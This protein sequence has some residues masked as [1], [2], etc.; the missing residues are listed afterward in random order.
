MVIQYRIK[1]M[2]LVKAYFYNLQHS[3]RTRLI[4]FS[5][6]LLSFAYNLFMGSSSHP[7]V[8]N[9]FVVAVMFA[10][11]L[12]LFIPFFSFITAKT[13][14]RNLYISPEGIET[15]IG[16][17]EGKI[18]WKAVDSITTTQDKI[19]ITG[20]SANAFSIPAS[21][22]NSVKERQQFIELASQYHANTK[23]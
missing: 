7:L 14:S 21:A 16:S 22:F 9:D 17:R 3:P 23:Q 19:I 5:G 20:K 8:L 11:A 1:R 12:I 18:P 6:A 10:V 2:D 15:K 4:V 13:Q